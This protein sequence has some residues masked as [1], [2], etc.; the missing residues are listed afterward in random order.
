MKHWRK[1]NTDTV[2]DATMGSY[3]GAEVNE[4]IGIY[5]Q[6]LL[7]NILSKD[8]MDLYIDDGLFI[9]YYLL[10]TTNRWNTNENNQYFQKYWL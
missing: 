8:N 3:D 9:T 7:T 5:I 1:K 6:F 10:F 4:L 2:F